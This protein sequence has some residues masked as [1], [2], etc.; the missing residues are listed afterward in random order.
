[1]VDQVVNH[2][3]SNTY[4]PRNQAAISSAYGLDRTEPCHRR[5]PICKFSSHFI[6]FEY[7]ATPGDPISHKF[8]NLRVYDTTRLV[9]NADRS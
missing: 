8:T 5:Q 1:M 4:S 7:V 3:G 9:E 6:Y 2:C